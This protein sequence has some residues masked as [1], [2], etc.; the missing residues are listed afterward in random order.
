MS[1]ILK[2]LKTIFIKCEKQTEQFRG[3]VAY[4]YEF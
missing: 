3:R 1:E 4:F 2:Y